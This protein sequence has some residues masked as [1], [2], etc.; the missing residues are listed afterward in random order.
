MNWL[1]LMF[2]K[3]SPEIDVFNSLGKNQHGSGVLALRRVKWDECA[4][5]ANLGYINPVS[6]QNHLS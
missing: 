2:E 6:K 3:R 4:F 1:K 5:E